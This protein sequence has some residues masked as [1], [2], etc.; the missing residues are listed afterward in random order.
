MNSKKWDVVVLGGIN[1]DYII[2]ADHLP[3]AGQTVQG[4]LFC[5]HAG[6]KG[7]NQAVAAA[8]LG[9][10][11][12]LIGRVGDE[13]RGRDLLRGLRKEKI[14]LDHVTR[15]QR[16]ATGAAI[17]AVDST[18]E[19]QITAA[20]GANHTM[21]LQQIRDSARIIAEARVLLMQF[22][23]PLPCVMLAAKIAK[24][25]GT[26]VVLDPAPPTQF[27]S[28]LYKFL[29]VIRPNSDEAEKLTGIKVQNRAEVRTAAMKLLRKGVGI[30]AMESG[31]GGDLILTQSEEHF[32]P[33]LKVK[34][35]DATGAGDAFAGAFAVGLAQALSLREI[36]QLA[37]AT[38]AL[39][40]TK[41]GAQEALPNRKEIDKLLRKISFAL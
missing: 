11:V 8:R 30:V 10:K 3:S 25:H 15:D 6:G 33:R 9:A 14:N 22:E 20:L 27:P 29:D 34:T 4:K 28:T 35:V 23:A 5:I 21:P 41:L 17:I 31:D 32:F 39:S 16:T 13:P 24:K 18:G 40:T 19:K 37:N 36:G 26:R 38:A 12:A 1:T 2:S 7:A